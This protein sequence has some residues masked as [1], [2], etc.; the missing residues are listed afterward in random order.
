VTAE[1]LAAK[2][3]GPQVQFAPDFPTAVDAVTAQAAKATSSSLS[4]QAASASWPR[5]SSRRW[6]WNKAFFTVPVGLISW[7]S[8]PFHEEREMDGARSSLQHHPVKMP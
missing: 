3:E 5:K 7:F 6:S 8:H 4:A 2:I 1:R